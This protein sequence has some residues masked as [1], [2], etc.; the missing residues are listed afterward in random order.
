MS[1][2]REVEPVENVTLTSFR[3][4]LFY[5][6]KGTADRFKGGWRIAYLILGKLTGGRRIDYSRGRFR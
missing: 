4:F 2:R 5:E 3:I 6:S 1:Q